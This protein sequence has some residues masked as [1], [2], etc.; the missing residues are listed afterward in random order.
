MLRIFKSVATTG[1]A[2]GLAGCW[3]GEPSESDMREALHKNPRFTGL[4]ILLGGIGSEARLREVMKNDRVEKSGCV[5]AGSAPGYI[6][7]A[8]WGPTLPNGEVR[9][10]NPFKA[11]FFKSGDGWAVELN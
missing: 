3:G 4:V 11:R 10:G 7:D 5:E 6:C 1:L 8:R 2:L 9:Y